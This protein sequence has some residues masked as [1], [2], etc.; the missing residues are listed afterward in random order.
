MKKFDIT[1][2]D[3]SYL[4]SFERE[5]HEMASSLLEGVPI[6]LAKQW[7]NELSNY[8]DSSFILAR[9]PFHNPEKQA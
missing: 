7:I 1:S 5:F 4:N 2:A 9:V 3:S 6:F 8:V